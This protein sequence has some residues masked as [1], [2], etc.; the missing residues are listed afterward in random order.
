MDISSAQLKIEPAIFET[1][2]LC[3]VPVRKPWGNLVTSILVA[4]L[5][6]LRALWSLIG[7]AASYFAKRKTTTGNVCEACVKRAE[8]TEGIH[9]SE[10]V[11]GDYSALPLESLRSH[12]RTNHDADLQ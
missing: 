5:V 6:F 1:N 3:Q 11:G 2:Y 9:G 4:D 10:K 7:V 8:N 12:E